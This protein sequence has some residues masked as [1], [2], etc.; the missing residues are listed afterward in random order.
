MTVKLF[1]AVHPFSLAVVQ[2]IE[3]TDISL[4]I[5]TQIYSDFFFWT[6]QN[7]KPMIWKTVSLATFFLLA[8]LSFIMYN[9]KIQAQQN[10]ILLPVP[11]SA[12][13]LFTNVF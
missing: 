8:G 13:F 4:A 2:K 11:H 12:V 9:Y 3:D 7:L 6:L 5:G 1:I 10:K